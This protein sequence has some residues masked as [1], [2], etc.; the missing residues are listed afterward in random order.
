VNQ[1]VDDATPSIVINYKSRKEAELAMS[2]GRNFQDRVLSITWVSGHHLLHRVG[3]SNSGTAGT[4]L[5]GTTTTQ[6]SEQLQSMTDEDIDLEVIYTLWIILSVSLSCCQYSAP[7]FIT[8]QS[9]L[10]NLSSIDY[11][12]L[13]NSNSTIC[14]AFE[15]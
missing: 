13:S 14:V 4:N 7:F 15:L 3:G 10:I 6:R 8:M 1:I 5:T 12:S 2:K 9:L 11:H